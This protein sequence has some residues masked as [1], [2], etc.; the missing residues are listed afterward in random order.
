MYFYNQI[1]GLGM[2][3]RR[4]ETIGRAARNILD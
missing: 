2:E 3:T 1:N 4:S